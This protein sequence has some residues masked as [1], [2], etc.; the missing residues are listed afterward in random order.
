MTG[1]GESAILHR[2]G[3]IADVQYAD[4]PNTWNFAKTIQRCYRNSVV[5]L[6]RAVDW[7]AN[8]GPVDFAINLG[9]I[10]DGC[11]RGHEGMGEAALSTVLKE[12][13]RGLLLS[14]LLNA[15]KR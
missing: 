14:I 13:Y 3:L 8:I 4:V 10:I 6:G 9:D 5:V 15:I 11:N 1:N 12:M 2:L 7:W